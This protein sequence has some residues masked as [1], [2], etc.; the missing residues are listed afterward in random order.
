MQA[1]VVVVVHYIVECLL[2][3]YQRFILLNDQR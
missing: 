1:V 2:F 3:V